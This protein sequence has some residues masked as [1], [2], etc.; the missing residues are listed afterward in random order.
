MDRQVH[1]AVVATRRSTA[2][3]RESVRRAR[4][5][6]PD[7]AVHVLDVDGGY[8]PAGDEHVLTPQD[9]G[10]EPH[11]VHALAARLVPQDLV[12]S[13]QPR[14]V[15]T[16]M[17]AEP[18][19]AEVTVLVIAAGVLLLRPP[20]EVLDGAV[21]HGIGLVARTPG[22]TPDD[23]LWPGVDD[24]VQAG[25]HSLSTLALHGQ[26]RAAL[27]VWDAAAT[28]VDRTGDRWLDV[29]AAQLPHHTVRDA[30]ALLSPWSLNRE[31]HLT[32]DAAGL[33]VDGRPVVA[34]DLSALDPERPWL[35]DGAVPGDPRGRLS[36][37]PVLARFV[38]R[39]AA[40]LHADAAGLAA[41]R[42]GEWDI[43][44]TSL[45]T[46]VDAPVRELY[47]VAEA[48]DQP[49]PDPVDPRAAEELRSWLTEPTADGGP[50]RYL[51][52]LHRTR[53]D[54]QR[55]FPDVPGKDTAG[56]LRWV[57]TY[58]RTE[59]YPADL[60]DLAL[61]RVDDVS[62][63][64]GR[65][66]GRPAR[67]RLQH[68][69]NVIGYLRGELGI[70]ESARLMIGALQAADV[71]H[72]TVSIDQ[73]LLSRQRPGDEPSGPTPSREVYDTSLI[74]VNADL[75]GVVAG[76]VPDLLS[77]SYRI[78]MWYWEV[79]DF[80][81][82]HDAFAHVDEVWTATDFVR[83]AVEPHSPVPVRTV[84]PPLP[85]RGTVPTLTRADLGLPDRPVFLFSFDFLS[86]AERKNPIGLID[87]FT[88]AFTPGEGPV[89]VIKSINADKRQ[90]D[91]ERLRLRAASEPDV[92]LME[93]YLDAAGRDALVALCDV[94]V[95]LHRSEGLGLTM[96]E[97]MA[98]GKPV[99]ATGY[100][101][102]LQFMTEENSYLVPWTP[103]RI[104]VG[105]DPYPAGGTW[106]EPDLVAAARLMRSVIEEPDVAAARGAR[107]ASDIAALH[108][109]EVAGR[110]IVER[111]AES[112]DRRRA[113]LRV[114]L[115]ERL[116]S[117]AR[118]LR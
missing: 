105:A 16:V 5:A 59:D 66:A 48:I 75:T 86:T 95:S 11:A 109:P 13:L 115:G 53:P 54:L 92:V 116:R 71:P 52:A 81:A 100:S 44:R 76:T 98:W 63:V 113:R 10:V 31:Q 58:G 47:R 114:S 4:A 107:A 23:G 49:A 56:F 88:T 15:R 41:A 68:G 67:V 28:R 12:R 72:S 29:V 110:Q 8:T 33:A 102:N 45:G 50:G 40:A 80:P 7:A 60:L 35:L 106:A 32:D 104:P 6:L 69:V 97:A 70:G 24:L 3:A 108:S 14:L 36:D 46:P 25:S 112:S 94:Y 61:S 93:D 83:R 43:S 90:A 84:T 99:I 55:S 26:Q 73:N 30:T 62:A 78:G 2:L 57:Q 87:A 9:I 39:A 85:Q 101:G 77:R 42:P 65:R 19:P 89:L 20:T 34:L 96:A 1:V 18:R 17:A 111:L 118:R 103:A 91:A 64:P 37:H 74:C 79:E 51:T 27:S 82:H 22:P 38:A 21:A 117:T